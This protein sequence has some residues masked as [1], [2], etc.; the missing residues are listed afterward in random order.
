[1]TQLEKIAASSELMC[2]RTKEELERIKRSVLSEDDEMWRRAAIELADVID[3]DWLLAVAGVRESSH[4]K[5]QE[6]WSD[7]IKAVL[8]P[9]VASVNACSPTTLCP[10][11]H[12]EAISDQ[13]TGLAANQ[14]TVLQLCQSYLET[15]GHVPLNGECALSQVL[16]A[17]EAG[18]PTPSALEEVFDWAEQSENP[19]ARYHACE[20]A[21]STAAQLSPEQRDR[22]ATWFWEALCPPSSLE[23]PTQEHAAWGLAVQLA[24]YYV[25]YLEVR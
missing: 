24:R 4:P 10:G 2:S 19:F 1:M 14:S 8:R 5:M 16:S 13:V 22:T 21:I 15:V 25:H 20:V 11:L 18:G 17:R 6:M 12:R 3:E 7:Y 23:D 9:S